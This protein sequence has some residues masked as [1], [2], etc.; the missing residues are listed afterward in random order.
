MQVHVQSRNNLTGLHAHNRTYGFINLLLG[1]G[2][3]FRC[4]CFLF[5]LGVSFLPFRACVLVMSRG[6]TVR[7]TISLLISCDSKC[8]FNSGLLLADTS[9]YDTCS[10]MN[11]LNHPPSILTAF[12]AGFL[13][14]ASF[15]INSLCLLCGQSQAVC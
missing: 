2:F 10:I 14:F 9:S 13:G 6:T 15:A 3:L 4:G 12:A 1:S 11:L 8:N 7:T 5:L